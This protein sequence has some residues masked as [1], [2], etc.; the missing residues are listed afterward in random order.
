[1]PGIFGIICRKPATECELALS[2]MGAAMR[3][4]TSCKA[5]T[6]SVPEM[7]VCCGWAAHENAFAADQPFLNEKEDVVLVLT[8]ECFLDPQ[9]GADL[10]RDGHNVGTSKA[11]WLV[12]LYEREG[13][14]LFGRLN[15]LFSGF[16]I[17]K[18]KGNA[19]LFNDRYGM[20][21][22]YW[23][24][25]ADAFYFASEAK[26]L[27]RILP[28]LRRFDDEGV[29]QYLT[30]GTTL[31]ERTL[32][33]GISTL[34]HGSL[35]SFGNG[36]PA[37]RRYFSP[38]SWESQT[39]LSV[40]SFDSSFQETFRRILPRYIE[41]DLKLGISLTAG[42]DTR[43]IMACLPEA[44]VDA[45]CYT[46][47]GQTGDI[48]DAKLAARVAATCGLQHKMLRLG[49]DFFGDFSRWVDKTIYT[50]DGYFGI[51]GAH[52]IYLSRQARQLSPIRLTG[53]FGGEILRS[54][55]MFKPLHLSP[56]LLQ[57]EMLP[58]KD[59]HERLRK[60]NEHPVTFA[61]FKE[62]PWN[63]FGTVS[64]CCSQLCLRTPYMDN[65]LVALAYRT[66]VSLRKS[67]DSAVT[68]IRN[69]N[70]A[71]AN[72]PTDMGYLGSASRPA[73][74][75]NKMAAKV[76]FRFDYHYNHG[77]PAKY[78]LLEPV[79]R[80]V[81][82]CMQHFGSHRYLRYHNWFRNELASYVKESLTDAQ[83]LQSPFWNAK[84]LKGLAEE[85]ISGRKNYEHEINAVI[86]LAAVERLLFRDLSHESEQPAQS[87]N[88]SGKILRS[89]PAIAG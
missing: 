84:F 44:G 56:D 19:F 50:T 21:R 25:T 27:L 4:E 85:H 38:E 35:W 49:P 72:I 5:G 62:M 70:K 42:M 34:P 22:I 33:K 2:S 41:S 53:I 65:E 37:R 54:V 57:P 11:S 46:Y 23:H 10:R 78:S 8:G 75:F 58:L 80:P 6:Y 12:H 29:A 31:E 64:A 63:R 52:E 26:A 82:A 73:S 69:N 86:T 77:L 7:G 81:A 61:A 71:V 76:L 83:T 47:S 1:M 13:D 15:G 88:D 39:P 66:P 3:L 20:E 51:T 14:K 59:A 60:Q 24:E 9:I 43:M 87:R 67:S 74:A 48:L 18:R 16:L 28:E 55:S 45:V 30:Y 68:F 32:F 79:F 36:T 89:S 40:E 17:D